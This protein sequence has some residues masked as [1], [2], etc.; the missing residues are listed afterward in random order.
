VTGYLTGIRTMH[1]GGHGTS[2]FFLG[3]IRTI[4][5]AASRDCRSRLGEP[6]PYLYQRATGAK[7][8][9]ALCGTAHN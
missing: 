5:P 7:R 8:Y 9:A 2:W 4:S 3:A 6:T 1:R